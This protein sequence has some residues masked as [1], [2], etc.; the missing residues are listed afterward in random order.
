MKQLLPGASCHR[1]LC[2]WSSSCLHRATVQVLV[3]GSQLLRLQ[4]PPEAE[5]PRATLAGR[6]MRQTAC[7][8]ELT[9]WAF[10]NFF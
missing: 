6:R 10:D 4:S 9:R 3:V 1:K 7:T 2:S 5:P 8:V